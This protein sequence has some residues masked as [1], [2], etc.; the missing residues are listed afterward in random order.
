MTDPAASFY[1]FGPFRLDAVKRLLL[2]EGRVVPLPPKALDTLLLLIE[3]SNRV[4]E[5]RELMDAIWPD[6][7]VEEANLTQNVS[8][9][10]KAL[11]ERADEHRYVVTVPGRGYRFV[12]N[13]ARTNDGLSGGIPRT[14]AIMLAE[15]EEG[16]VAR[17][18]I[19]AHRPSARGGLA[20]LETEHCDRKR[21]EV[22]HQSEIDRVPGSS[23]VGTKSLDLFN[24]GDQVREL[25]RID[26]AIRQFRGL[27]EAGKSCQ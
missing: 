9:L 15:R 10:R 20:G 4:V 18:E 12:A 22:P 6:S 5:K 2:Q 17:E 3:N 1:E 23:F 16:T 11:G 27:D 26:D 13:L 21:R 25:R 19:E 14:Q 24:P 8:I 7:F